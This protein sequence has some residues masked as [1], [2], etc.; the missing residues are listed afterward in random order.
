MKNK[1]IAILGAITDACMAF[2]DFREGT[3]NGLLKIFASGLMYV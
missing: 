3:E 2:H 1:L